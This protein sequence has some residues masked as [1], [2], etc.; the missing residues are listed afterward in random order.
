MVLMYALT[1]LGTCSSG[2]AKAKIRNIT[3]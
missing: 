3:W 2:K 1:N